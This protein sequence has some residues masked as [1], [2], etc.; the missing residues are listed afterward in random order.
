MEYKHNSLDTSILVRLFTG[1]RPDLYQRIKT[2]ISTGNRFFYI[3][4]L[5]ITELIYVLSDRGGVYKYPRQKVADYIDMVLSNPLF[6]TNTTRME[7]VL[8]IYRAHPK[9]SFNDC[10]LAVM[11]EERGATPLWTLDH[12]LALQTTAASEFP[13]DLV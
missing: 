13:T 10:Y 11:A 5:A 9:L 7:K 2:F 3:E 1:D 6:I 4:D 8:R 12:K